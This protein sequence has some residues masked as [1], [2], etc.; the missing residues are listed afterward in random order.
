MDEGQGHVAEVAQF[1]IGRKEYVKQLGYK[2]PVLYWRGEDPNDIPALESLP[3]R[4]VLK[5][6]EDG[7]P[8]T[9]TASLTDTTFDSQARHERSDFERT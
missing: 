3:E 7:V 8:T 1:K 6:A 4:F 2:V 5:P 9:C